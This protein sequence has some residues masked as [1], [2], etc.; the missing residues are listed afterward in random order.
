MQKQHFPRENA[1]RKLPHYLE[2]ETV[3]ILIDEAS[4]TSMM[5]ANLLLTMW[6]A[7][8]RVTEAV[9]LQARDLRLSGDYPQIHVRDGKGQKERYIPA[10]PELRDAL[11]RHCR[12]TRVRGTDPIFVN[13]RSGKKASRDTGYQWVMRAL[14]RAVQAGRLPPGTRAT[15]HTFRHSAARHW[16]ANGV[17]INVVQRWLG[18]ESLDVTLIYLALVPDL[19]HTM[20]HIP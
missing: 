5:A 16:L 7:G 12:Y 8:L 15:P 10:H 18:H 20:D 14:S 4:S 17:P 19:S 2:A 13:E 11:R 1:R 9:N 3:D 6:R